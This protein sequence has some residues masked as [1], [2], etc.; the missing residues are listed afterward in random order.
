VPSRHPAENWARGQSADAMEIR[1]GGAYLVTATLIPLVNLVI[2][3]SNLRI[4]ATTFTARRRG[5]FAG[6]VARRCVVLIA[7][8]SDERRALKALQSGADEVVLD[9]VDAVTAGRRQRHTTW[10]TSW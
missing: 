1:V 9:P 2:R 5:V 7:P 10:C 3:R 6:G 8:G 4:S